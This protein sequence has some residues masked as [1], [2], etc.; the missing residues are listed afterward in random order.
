MVLA[1]APRRSWNRL[2]KFLISLVE[3]QPLGLS[4]G[5]VAVLQEL[6]QETIGMSW[7]AGITPCCCA[8][9][10]RQA[11]PESKSGP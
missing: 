3:L 6:C 8:A 2:D 10:V 11:L 7:D 5:S 4:S 1:D 9:T